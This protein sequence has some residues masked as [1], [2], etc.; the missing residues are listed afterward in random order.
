MSLSEAGFTIQRSTSQS[1]P[2]GATTRTVNLAGAKG[3]YGT[4]VTWLDNVAGNQYFYRVRSYK[5]DADY[6]T[7]LI[8]PLVGPNTGVPSTL[9]NLVS[10]WTGVATATA[11]P[12]MNVSPASLTFGARNYLTTSA[13]Q[14]VTITSAGVVN[15]VLNAPPAI[16][17]TNQADFTIT[18]STCP[19]TPTP[20]APGATCTVSVAFRPTYAGP[21]T[22]SLLISSNANLTTIPLTGTGNSIPVTITA[23]TVTLTW[24]ATLNPSLVLV[25]TLSIATPDPLASFA[26]TCSAS[27]YTV[28]GGPAGTYTT[29]CSVASNPNNA[30]TIT[31][32]TGKLTVS[33]T[34]AT[35][36]S[37][38]PGTV[39]GNSQT[40][41]WTTGGAAR[42]LWPLDLGHRSGT[43]R[44][45][46]H[47]LD[48]RNLA[49]RHQSAIH[50]QHAVREAANAGQRSHP[51]CRLHLHRTV[52]SEGG[53][54]GPG[55]WTAACYCQLPMDRR[56]GCDQLRS[57]GLGS[58]TRPVRGLPV[59]RPWPPLR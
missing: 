48:Q 4:T 27:G 15:L 26:I 42:V 13:A 12:L 45:P 49:A 53:A 43:K 14:T 40:F 47:W 56:P 24:S 50:R 54:H 10:T 7:P 33:R 2:T 34:V 30:Y 55:V 25:P 1:F 20:L 6:W 41:T 51:V 11:A 5:L 35:M 36:I 18:G 38:T 19:V 59:P 31:F 23:P 21:R 44:T 3:G 58:W 9:P 37:P 22:A 32:V 28:P 46:K 29:S 8:G 16:S 39:V 17:G 52:T 57:M